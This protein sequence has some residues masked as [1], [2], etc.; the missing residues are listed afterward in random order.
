MTIA[1]TS[2]K[3]IYQGDAVTSE[4]SIP[5]PFFDNSHIEVRL[6]SASGNETVWSL[7]SEYALAGAGIEA[8]GTL[9]VSTL[10]FDH[11][12][13]VGANLV[14]RRVVPNVQEIDYP[15]GG[16]FPARAH[17]QG[18]DLSVMRDQQLD[19][20]LQRSLRFPVS[21]PAESTGI[22]PTAGQR[23]NSVLGFDAEGNPIATVVPEGG[24]VVSS[25]MATMLDDTDPADARS[26]LGAGAAGDALFTA[27]SAAAARAA[28]ASAAL[29]S[30]NVFTKTQTW[31]DGGNIASAVSLMLGDGNIFTITGTT[32]ITSIGTKGV[33]TLVFLRFAGALT[34]THHATDLVTHTGANIVTMAGDWALIEEYAAGDW[35]VI[36]FSRPHVPYARI[37]DQ[38]TS[39]TSGGASTG[40]AWNTR[41][42][43]TEAEDAAGLVS[44]SSNRITL[45]N[46]TY[47]VKASAPG[48]AS[49]G[50]KL[51][52]RNITD[53]ATALIGTTEYASGGVAVTSRSLVEGTLVVSGGPKVYELQQWFSASHAQGMGAADA[54][55][56]IEIFVRIEIWRLA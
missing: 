15:E 37:E 43:N 6:R 26:T 28:L 7:G 35:R 54:T 38:K 5:F 41:T 42:L 10:P 25:F 32:A 36:H 8:G 55:G 9:T 52:L 23:A 48:Y 33:G 12:P 30:A 16:A 34:L 19:E 51:R 17:E 27:A 4:F 53:G 31:K 22:L 49:N 56:E 18:L 11:T 24:N 13:P 1:S 46:G 45:E 20:T 44:L 2:S 3:I 39:G 14:I 50:H 47:R 29:A 40:A 21:D